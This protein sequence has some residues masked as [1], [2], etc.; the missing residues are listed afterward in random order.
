MPKVLLVGISIGDA[1]TE[2][3][4][5][6]FRESQEYYAT[7]HG[8]DFKVCTTHLDPNLQLYETTSFNKALV[9]CQ[10]WSNNYD[11]I[12]FLDSDILI[13][14]NAPAIHT[15]MDYEDCIGIVDEFSQPSKERRLRIH[16]RLGWE[17]SATEY[18]KLAGYDLQ[19]DIGFNTGMFIIQPKLHG[20]LLK[21][22]YNKYVHNSITHWRGFHYEQSSIGYEIQKSKKYKIL[23]NKF[24]A[25]WPIFKLDNIENYTLEQYFENNYFVHFAGKGDHDKVY[26]LYQRHKQRNH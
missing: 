23:D 20:D 7:K 9:G 14:R 21:N 24:N 18:Y 1:Y 19:T 10:E 5:N 26:E 15:Y 13:N 3:Y 12:V 8:Y 17:K 6:L 2:K 16:N 22:T 4:N 11:F 25:L